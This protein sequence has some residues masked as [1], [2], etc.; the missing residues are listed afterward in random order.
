[1]AVNIAI[2]P[3]NQVGIDL[4][5]GAE[6]GKLAGSASAV[7]GARENAGERQAGETAARRRALSSRALSGKSVRPVKR[8]ASAQSVL[9]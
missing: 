4:G 9:P 7:A 2:I 1:M 8:W 3:F 5:G 6:S